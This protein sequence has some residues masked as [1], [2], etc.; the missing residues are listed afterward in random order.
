MKI[1]INFTGAHNRNVLGRNDSGER[2]RKE[3]KNAGCRC[4]HSC[5]RLFQEAFIE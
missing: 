5:D 3:G 1:S 2:E 4:I